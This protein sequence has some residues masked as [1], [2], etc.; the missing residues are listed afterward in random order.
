MNTLHSSKVYD[1]FKHL[2]HAT[3]DWVTTCY[4]KLPP[5]TMTALSSPNVGS[6]W[7]G[8]F[9]GTTPMAVA[10]VIPASGQH[11]RGT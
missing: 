10:E 4:R 7:A 8:A 5:V 6:Y 9:E 3:D 2:R 11:E 1:N